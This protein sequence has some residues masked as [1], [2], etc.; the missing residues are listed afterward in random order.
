[1]SADD[2]FQ[3]QEK[4]KPG[5]RTDGMSVSEYEKLFST[6]IQNADAKCTLRACIELG[7]ELPEISSLLQKQL[8]RWGIS[9]RLGLDSV[10]MKVWL[11][12]RHNGLHRYAEELRELSRSDEELYRRISAEVLDSMRTTH[13]NEFAKR[14]PEVR[15]AV[16][17]L[18]QRAIPLKRIARIVS[19][20]FG[21]KI[22]EGYFA[23]Q[24]YQEGNRI[25]ERASNETYSDVQKR[26]AQELIRM[27]TQGIVVGSPY[28]VESLTREQLEQGAAFIQP[29]IN[30]SFEAT[31]EAKTYKA[32]WHK[33]PALR[34]MVLACIHADE[35]TDEVQY[36]DRFIAE[37]LTACSGKE[38]W[39]ISVADFRSDAHLVSEKIL[40][41]Q[42][43]KVSYDIT[44]AALPSLL[45]TYRQQWD[46]HYS[47]EDEWRKH[48][49]LALQR[50]LRPS[51]FEFLGHLRTGERV[52]RKFYK[53]E[54]I[55]ASVPHKGELVP[56]PTLTI[57]FRPPYALSDEKEN[58]AQRFAYTRAVKDV[59]A[60]C[61]DMRAGV[62]GELHDVCATQGIRRVIV[63]EMHG[64]FKNGIR[65]VKIADI[66]LIKKRRV[67]P[68]W[69]D[70]K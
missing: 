44:K 24:S 50:I 29:H 3:K 23:L 43:G 5:H 11:S 34:A 52:D 51:F 13:P 19:T 70:V 4:T 68:Q 62:H 56:F 41:K 6:L 57:T 69:S 40:S 10:R 59:Q 35:Q 21:I 67:R 8:P 18:L 37:L 64:D 14:N 25:K 16:V 47:S 1:M 55:T 17:S 60:E 20:A 49:L 22:T 2:G 15:A 26:G 27:Y 31:V 63:R 61:K 66:A 45:R 54:R 30:A 46:L 7:M 12:E 33:K 38:T 58:R 36:S 39:P 53:V 48:R 28:H 9:T 42:E 32:Y 65:P